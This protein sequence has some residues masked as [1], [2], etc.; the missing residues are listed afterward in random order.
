MDKVR[1]KN[2]YNQIGIVYNPFFREN[3]AFD[4]DSLNHI[5]SSKGKPRPIVDVVE[6]VDLIKVG[7]KLLETQFPPTEYSRREYP[8]DDWVQVYSFIYA[9]IDLEGRDYKLKMVIREKADKSKHFYSVFKLPHQRH[10]KIP[11]T[12]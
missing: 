11:I 6:R 5:F 8:S 3:L 10:K 1:I 2:E 7:V 12:G 9:Y 4:F